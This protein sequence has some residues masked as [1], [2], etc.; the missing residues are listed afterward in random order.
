MPGLDLLLWAATA[1]VELYLVG[2]ILRR[3]LDRS[4][5]FLTAYLG[6]NLLQ[7]VAQV[8]VYQFYGFRSP[9]TYATIW[10]SQAVVILAR[11]LAT[12]EFCHRVLGRYVGVWALAIRI[13]LASGIV[14]L[15]LALYFGRDGFRYGVMTLE[16]AS[17]GF[18]ATLVAGTFLFARYYEARLQ[19]SAVLLGLGLGLNSCVKIL[20]DVVLSRYIADYGRLWNSVGMISF[21]GVLVFWIFA[22][23]TAEE[24]ELREPE[25]QSA[26]VYRLLAPQMNRR[27]AELN[28]HLVQLL[29]PEHPRP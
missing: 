28:Q 15:G 27:L 18:I 16:I 9:I 17:E 21:A 11:A 3:R 19:M 29:K 26:D 6:V 4:F 22:M 20:N 23:R 8:M 12:C 10:G 7:T 1:A 24:G 13:L 14:V 5:P 25:L 2:M